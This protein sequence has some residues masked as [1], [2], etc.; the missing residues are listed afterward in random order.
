MGGNELGK[1]GSLENSVVQAVTGKRRRGCLDVVRRGGDKEKLGRSAR[2][3]AWRW[4]M[5]WWGLTMG[6]GT[7]GG[8]G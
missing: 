6:G 8:D 5:W 4:W 7:D 2:V 1:G 3:W